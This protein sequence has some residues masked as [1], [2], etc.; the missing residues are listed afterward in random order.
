MNVYIW[1]DQWAPWSD[2][3]SYFPFKND[4]LDEKWNNVIISPYS[5]PLK[6]SIGYQFEWQCYISTKC[7]FSC[8]R[9]KIDLN[10]SQDSNIQTA[11]LDNI[12]WLSYY[13]KSDGTNNQSFIIYPWS[14]TSGS[15]RQKVST[16]QWVWYHMW[17]GY[18]N[19]IAYYYF[20]WQRYQL[21][22]W[23]VTDFWGAG[24]FTAFNWHKSKA[25]ISDWILWNSARSQEQYTDYYNQ[26]KSL[27]WIS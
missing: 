3:I 15:I 17:V 2:I 25:T 18:G 6:Q 24:F 19:W 26:T 14:T 27:Y 22:Q 21:Y 16:S 23:S 20:N 1:T 5:T 13:F 8:C 9:V 4:I 7:N 10:S 11:I 12:W